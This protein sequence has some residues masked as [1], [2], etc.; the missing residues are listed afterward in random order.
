M[1]GNDLIS[2]LVKSCT[3]D[4]LA[5][6][7]NQ[8][9]I[10]IDIDDDLSPEEMQAA[11]ELCEEIDRY[12]G[13]NCPTKDSIDNLHDWARDFDHCEVE[14]GLGVIVLKPDEE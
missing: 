6:I 5:L 11:N 12:L 1:N 10:G 9:V 8:L 14:I 3:S 13:E 7:Q 2:A 4:T